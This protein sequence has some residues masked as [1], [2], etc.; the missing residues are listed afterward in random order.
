MNAKSVMAAVMI[1][2]CWASSAAH[3][4]DMSKRSWSDAP[5]SRPVAETEEA[6][7]GA[8]AP[9]THSGLSDWIT[10]KRDNCCDTGGDKRPLNLASELYLRAGPSVPLGGSLLGRELVTGWVIM[11]GARALFFDQANTAAWTIDAHL[12]HTANG[13]DGTQQIPLNIIQQG[14]RVQF[15]NGGTRPGVTIHQS[16]RTLAGLG[17]GREY[18]LWQSAD[19][20]GKHWRVGFDAG[21]RYGSGS[22]KFNEIRHRTD[23]MGGAFTAA[24]SDFEIPCGCCVFTGGFRLEW[25]YTWSDILQRPSDTQDLNL[26]FTLGCRY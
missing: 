6:A 4:Q 21:G 22:M 18:Y 11:G 10:Y 8:A 15:G 3:G 12:I 14:Q 7:T 17:F 24:H 25:A 1:G 2:L 16:S 26:L 19:S 13:A 20:P 5:A 9:P 23:V